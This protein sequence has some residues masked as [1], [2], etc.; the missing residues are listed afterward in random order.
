[1]YT[2]IAMIFRSFYCV[3]IPNWMS[4]RMSSTWVWYHIF[5]RF[6]LCFFPVGF[7]EYYWDLPAE[8]R[9]IQERIERRRGSIGQCQTHQSCATWQIQTCHQLFFCA[10]I[11]SMFLFQHR[12][13]SWGSVH[14]GGYVTMKWQCA[15]SV[16]SLSMLWHGGDTTAEPAAM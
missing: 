16:K 7:P 2:P 12:K 1:M 6:V 15:W 8:K 11:L 4:L 13:Q 3:I 5:F 9:V 10:V 14:H